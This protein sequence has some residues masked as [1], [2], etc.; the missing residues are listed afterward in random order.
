MGVPKKYHLLLFFLRASSLVPASYACAMFLY[1]VDDLSTHYAKGLAVKITWIDYL[2]ACMWCMLAG[3]WSYWL[4]DSLMRRWIFYYKVSSAIIRLISL[5]AINW[6]ATSYVASHYGPD[7]PVWTWIVVSC[8]LAVANI[9]Q[10]LFLSTGHHHEPA[11]SRSTVWKDIMKFILIPLSIVSFLTMVALLEQEATL[12]YPARFSQG[13]YRLST[14]LTLDDFQSTSRVKVLMVVLT[15][16]TESG[17]HKRQMFRESSAKLIPPHSDRISVA[18]RFIVGSPT[19]VKKR[20]ELGDKLMTEN[21]QYKD[22]VIVPAGDS[23]EELSHKVYKAFEWTNGFAFDYI[24]KTDDDMFVRMDVVTRELDELGPMRKYYWRGL[25][26]WNIPPIQ[27]SSNKNAAFDY[28]LPLFPPF[29]AGALYILSRDLISL[30]VTDTPRVFTKNEDQNLGIWLFPYNIQPIHDKRIQQADVCEDDM[31]AKHFSD[32]YGITRSMKD[33]YENVINRRR[34]CEGFTQTYCALCYSC[35][36]RVNH[37]REWGFECDDTKGI[38][39]LNQP[40]LFLPDAAYAIKLFDRE[41]MT[42]GSK[43]DEWI[44]EGLLSKHSSIYSDTEQW[45]LLHWMLWVTDQSTFLERHYK[46]IEMIWVHTPNAVIFVVSTTLPSDFFSHYQKQ[47]YQI[48]VIKISKDLLIERQWYLGWNSRDWLKYWDKWQNSQF[49]VYHMADF[50]RY[51]LLYKYGGMYMDMDALW[52]HAPP[53]NQ[54]EFIGSDYSSVDADR[55]WTLD[56]KNTY[57]ANGVMRLRKGRAMLREI[58]E[59]ALD[60]SNYSV[61]CFNCVGPRALTMYVRDNR[62]ILEQSGLVI[63]PNYIL[64]PRDYLKIPTLLKQ[65][66]KAAAELGSIGKRSWSIHLFGKMTNHLVIESASVVGLTIKKF[67]LDIPHPPAPETSTSKP[68]TK[69]TRKSYPF[70]LSGPK[71]YK[72]TLQRNNNKFAGSFNG[73]FNGFDA[74]FLRGG[75]G[76]CKKATISINA[77]VGRMSFGHLGGMWSNTTITIDG[78][79]KKDVNAILNGLTYHPNE[80][81]KPGKD[82]VTVGIEFDGHLASIEIDVLVPQIDIGI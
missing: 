21:E 9:I 10:W 62:K 4:A 36:G 44:I 52:I 59:K 45:Y 23:Y 54:M 67:S 73:Q 76:K 35:G 68:D 38:T 30:I 28:K 40:K 72:Y 60:P 82:K 15:S 17:F 12:R 69:N 66:N 81:L 78:A 29:T 63:L 61:Y 25:G 65:D 39:L 34:M 71:T 77:A 6:V 79:T 37:W 64:Y 1:G 57:L 26:Y 7:Q 22:L 58:T 70:T 74:I 27:D 51:V 24:V 33:M 47:G 42:I 8:I 32:S 75:T 19:S 56:E 5:Q 3:L 31:I 49:F 2:I 50:V 13:G 80:L 18:Y 46:T 16:W 11:T 43:E 55:E 20:K 41:N 14:N 53:D 48:H